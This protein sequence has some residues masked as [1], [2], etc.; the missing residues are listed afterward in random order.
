MR[1]IKVL[2]GRDM[3]RMTLGSGLFFNLRS[4]YGMCGYAFLSE[5][6]ITNAESYQIPVI[7]PVDELFSLKYRWYSIKDNQFKP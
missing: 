1:D 4:F 3:A 6:L 5:M 7:V 2:V